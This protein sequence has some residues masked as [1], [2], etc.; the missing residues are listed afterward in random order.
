MSCEPIRA[1]LRAA[2]DGPWPPEVTAHLATCGA[3]VDAAIDQALKQRP[4]STVPSSFAADVARAARLATPAPHR[5]SRALIA[6]MAAAPLAV[7]ASWV[8]LSATNIEHAAVPVAAFVLACAVGLAATASTL[9]ADVVR[10]RS[11][12]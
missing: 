1:A 2:G 12:G 8:W 3:C 4:P 11:R 10:P 9:N 7:A 5:R 6:G